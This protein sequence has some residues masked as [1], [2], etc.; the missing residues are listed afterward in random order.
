MHPDVKHRRVTLTP[1]EVAANVVA[2]Q[3]FTV[4]DVPADNVCYG[5]QNPDFGNA[6]GVVGV[7]V[8]AK[9]TVA[10]RFNNPTAG[11]LT[12]GAGVWDFFF[13]KPQ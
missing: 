11:A 10:I 13:C 2:E 9:D 12:P 4:S 3:T 7:R 8:S 1:V 6:T 5:Y